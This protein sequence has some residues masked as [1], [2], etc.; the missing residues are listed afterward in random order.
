MKGE[1]VRGGEGGDSE[2][3]EETL[4][5]TP[6]RKLQGRNQACGGTEESGWIYT[7]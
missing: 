2:A 7:A 5:C 3:K 4:A 1:K 6:G